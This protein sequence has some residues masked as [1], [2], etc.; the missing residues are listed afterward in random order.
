MSQES[1]PHTPDEDP[2]RYWA[3][4]PKSSFRKHQTTKEVGKRRIAELKAMINENK[5]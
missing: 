4:P 3:Q 1:K 2:D 5:K